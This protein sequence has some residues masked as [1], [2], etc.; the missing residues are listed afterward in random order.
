M[1]KVKSPRLPAR[2]VL[3]RLMIYLAVVTIALPVSVL[4]MMVSTPKAQAAGKQKVNVEVVKKTDTSMPKETLPILKGS[5]GFSE[6]LTY[7]QDEAIKVL[8]VFEGK[9]LRSWAEVGLLDRSFP[10]TISLK[11]QGDGSWLLLTPKLTNN[12]NLGY[13][14]LRVF[15]ENSVGTSVFSFQLN[16]KEKLFRITPKTII[17]EDEIRLFWQP[18]KKAQKYLI[19]WNIRGESVFHLNVAPLPQAILANLVSGTVY[20][21]EITPIGPDGVLG[22][23]QE[24]DLKTQGVAPAK[25][26]VLGQTK[27]VK[28]SIGEGISTVQAPTVGKKTAEVPPSQGT[29]SPQASAGPEEKTGGW[30]RLLVALAILIIAAGAAVGGYYGYEWYVARSSNEKP[31][32]NKS[33]SRW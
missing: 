7:H 32:D 16:L 30:N 22:K 9:V 21:I 28:P 29:P 5:K 33:S 23:A 12:F 13:Q 17:S 27:R 20:E 15:A 26:T 11:N 25:E 18:V 19:S 1:I 6:G 31:P 8:F 14:N 10:E 2:Q 4:A 3:K 24:M